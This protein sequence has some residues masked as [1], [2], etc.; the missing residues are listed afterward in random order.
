MALKRTKP[1]RTV[2]LGGFSFADGNIELIHPYD[3]PYTILIA[4]NTDETSLEQYFAFSHAEGVLD[5]DDLLFLLDMTAEETLELAEQIQELLFGEP[6]PGVKQIPTRD[7][8]SDDEEKMVSE[9]NSLLQGLFTKQ[10]ETPTAPL[11]EEIDRV[12]SE[13]DPSKDEESRDEEP[14]C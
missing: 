7:K 8:L 14:P 3:V 5:D 4:F 12:L 1:R 11:A 9:F 6:T 10:E 2:T 13:D